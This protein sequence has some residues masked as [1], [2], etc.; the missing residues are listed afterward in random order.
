MDLD[1]LARFAPFTGL[2]PE[3]LAPLV[4]DLTLCEVPA[5]TQ[6]FLQGAPVEELFLILDGNVEGTFRDA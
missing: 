5:D 4:P 1:T 2:L 3:L 6:L